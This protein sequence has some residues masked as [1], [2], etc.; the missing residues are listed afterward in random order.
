M[1]VKI[2]QGTETG[3]KSTTDGADEI[4]HVR[5]DGGTI[6]LVTSVTDV[7]SVAAVG[8]IHNAGTIAEL[9]DLLG[10]TIDEVT[11][12]TEVANLATGTITKIEGG[13]LDEVGI[14]DIAGGTIDL[15]TSV[16][17]LGSV[18]A[19]G[20]IHNAGTIA[21]LPDPLGSVVVTAGTVET[22]IGDIAGGTI[23]IITEITNIAGGTVVTTMGDLTGGTLD[24][25]SAL[26]L[27]TVTGVDANAAA[28]TA[29]PVGV[30]GTDSG[31]TIRTVLVDA[32][33]AMA[34]SGASAGTN[35]NIVTGTQQTLG[36]VG[37]VDNIVTGTLAEVGSIGTVL[38]I[39]GGSIANVG[40][41]HNAGTV[42]AVTSVTEVANLAT[43]TVAEVTSVAELVKGTVTNVAQV[44]N[45]AAGTLTEVGSVGTVLGIAGGSIADVAEVHTI[46]T[47][48]S[49]TAIGAIHNAGTVISDTPYS[50]SYNVAGTVNHVVKAGAGFLHAILVG[51]SVASS[52]IEVSDHASDGDGAVVLYLA[53]DTLGPALYPVNMTMGTGISTD[54]TNQTHV[55]FIY[56]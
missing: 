31:G 44:D 5:N 25:I 3:I 16:S 14:G 32:A 56:K 8:I 34:V 6:G 28:Q 7:G 36:T 39:A 45:V 20:V 42:T 43:G 1:S 40:V 33:G 21:E 15:I 4:Q 37:V 51:D 22:T 52:I 38:G 12:V 35:V 9:P 13:T 41:I 17:D 50:Y 26:A 49:I 11:S 29:N 18:A 2:T 19:I 46:G 30:G 47:I 48:G 55:T 54:I 53:G 23:D 10:G 24:L 27:G